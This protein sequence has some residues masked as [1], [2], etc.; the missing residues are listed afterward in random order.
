MNLVP[1]PID[2]SKVKAIIYHLPEG[3][4]IVLDADG[5]EDFIDF[6]FGRICDTSYIDGNIHFFPEG[7][8]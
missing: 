6:S 4:T 7:N 1:K 5:L 8:A 2:M 3:D